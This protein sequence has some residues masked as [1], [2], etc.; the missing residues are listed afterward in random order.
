[1][2]YNNIIQCYKDQLQSLRMFH[3]ELVK[4]N[5]ITDELAIGS[6][7]TSILPH[8]LVELVEDVFDTNIQIKNRSQSVIFGR[9][10]AAYILKKYT[11]LSLNEIAKYIGVGD[12]TTAIYNIKTAENL[13]QTEQWYKE[14]V[15]EI[16]KEIENFSN[17]IKE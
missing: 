12:H 14:K 5:L 9:K 8:R 16:E 4:A 6:M 3:K 7:S 11:Q 10:A 13:M 1:M 2:E 17:F 15:D